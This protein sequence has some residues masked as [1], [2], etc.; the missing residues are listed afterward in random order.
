MLYFY[1]YSIIYLALILIDIK[2][3]STFFDTMKVILLKIG[4]TGN[5]RGILRLL[6]HTA[7]MFSRKFVS[8][9]TDEN[10]CFFNKFIYLF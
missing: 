8:I 10:I 1:G 2:E 7:K 4:K 6:I 3:V 5:S 9:T